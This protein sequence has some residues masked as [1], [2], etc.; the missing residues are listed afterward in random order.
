MDEMCEAGS[1]GDPDQRSSGKIRE[2]ERN[3]GIEVGAQMKM[4]MKTETTG[5]HDFTEKKK[6]QMRFVA[7]DG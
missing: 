3:L 5:G 7:E 1:R 2:S 6:I 4:V